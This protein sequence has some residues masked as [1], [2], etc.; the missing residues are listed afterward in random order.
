MPPKSNTAP[1]VAAQEYAAF[2]DYLAE[3]RR[4]LIDKGLREGWVDEL[5]AGDQNFIEMSFERKI[6]LPIFVAFEI[7][8]AEIES[9]HD[10]VDTDCQLKIEVS[11]Q[12][13]I[14]L[15]QLVDIGLWGDSVEGVAATLVQQQLAAK[16]ES[17]LLH[18][19]ANK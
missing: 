16:L 19:V 9:S 7:F 13:K 6:K 2:D 4:L 3:V 11:D 10:P 18:V 12:S 5:I 1:R 14:F 15:Q 17:K 8:A